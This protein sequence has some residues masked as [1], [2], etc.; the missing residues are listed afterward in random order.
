MVTMIVT[1][2]TMIYS[3]DNGYGDGD[4]G[5]YG[6]EDGY[7]DH[8]NGDARYREDSYREDPGCRLF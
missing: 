7:R 5:A 1:M 2:T 6:H 8:Y 3:Y 4:V